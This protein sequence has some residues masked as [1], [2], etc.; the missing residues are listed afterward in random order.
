MTAAKRSLPA[1]DFSNSP[2]IVV[3]AQVRMTPV[4]DLESYIPKLQNS[5]RSRGYP[6]LLTRKTKTTRQDSM[7]QTDLEES[8]DWVF[9][10]KQ[11][12]F[13]F[14]VG[15][16]SLALVTSA[17]DSF[18]DFASRLEEGL[19]LVHEVIEV[20]GVERL[21]L[22]YVDLIEP[23]VE[24][25][26]SYFVESSVLGVSLEEFGRRLS[27]FTRATFQTAED[28]RLFVQTVERPAGLII[29]PDLISLQLKLRKP[30]F[31][32]TAFGILDFDHFSEY[33][34][35]VDYSTDEILKEFWGLHDVVDKAFRKVTTEE[36]KRDWK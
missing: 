5:L 16:R 30:E 18:D 35:A 27:G 11:A 36:A 22:R 8:T 29:P 34:Q 9:S 2:L 19:G 28:R 31:M 21:G 23:S 20:T 1:L 25:P 13:C 10:D 26:L 33:A 24:K 32:E 15:E 4:L 3:L 6:R 7:G 14:V 12:Q 17:Y